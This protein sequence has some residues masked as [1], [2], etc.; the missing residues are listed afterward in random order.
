MSEDRS[1]IDHIASYRL[2]EFKDE[3]GISVAGCSQWRANAFFMAKK[4]LP[5]IVGLMIDGKISFSDRSEIDELL[6][7]DSL[8]GFSAMDCTCESVMI[9]LKAYL[10]CIP[11]FKGRYFS[12]EGV[13]LSCYEHH[14]YCLMEIYDEAER[15]NH[16]N[17]LKGL[18]EE[19]EL[20]G[21]G[22]LAKQEK[23]YLSSTNVMGL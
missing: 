11:G 22:I 8:I 5:A 10:S 1:T 2:E 15:R 23:R 7:L 6:S 14:G 12:G 21:I 4:S 9:D 13:D 20:V 16:S 18:K 17:W 19:V 3:M